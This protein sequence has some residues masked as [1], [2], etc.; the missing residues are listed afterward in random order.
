MLRSPVFWIVIVYT[1]FLA[2]FT[3]IKDPK[4]VPYPVAQINFK[5]SRKYISSNFA[6]AARLGNHI[7]ELASILSISRYLNRV[8]IFFFE[9]C[10]HEK[11][12]EDTNNLIPGLM[13]QFLVINGSIPRSIRRTVFHEKCCVFDNPSVLKGNEDEYLHLEG[14]NYQSWKYFSQMRNELIGSLKSPTNNFSN[15]PVSS[16][17][18]SV[19][20][21]HIRR[22]DFL[23]VN[24]HVASEHFIKSSMDYVQNQEGR[25]RKHMATVF[26][27]DDF[28]F[29]DSL[30]NSTVSNS[31]DAFVSR[32]LP[33][34]DLLY[35]KAN[36]DVVII[37]SAHSTFGW[38]MGYLSKGNTVYYTDIKYTNDH[39]LGTGN[40]KSE[41]Y[42]PPHWTPLKYAGSNNL[43]V[44]RSFN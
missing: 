2:Y 30:R 41:D 17:T 25:S 28:S 22:G 34:D 43:T 21:I 13:N 6:A 4:A 29:M 24:F 1:I 5:T 42:Y 40:F 12:W 32:N 11:M 19:T 26:F 20:C 10:Y 37:T 8:P 14:Y 15:L 33:S 39:I 27:G 31:Q 23:L 18:T 7:F 38:W 35:S 44:T 16:Q 3:L 36:C 9:D